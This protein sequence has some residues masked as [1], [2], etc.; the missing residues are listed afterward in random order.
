MACWSTKAAISL[1][2]VKI[3]IFRAPICRAHRAAIFAIAQL[4]C[5]GL[6]RSALRSMSVKRAAP[7]GVNG[8]TSVPINRPLPSPEIVPTH[9]DDEDEC[10]MRC[11]LQGRRDG[12]YMGIYTSPQKESVQ[13]DFLWGTVTRPSMTE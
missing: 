10:M 6:V 1:K 3:E 5:N 9:S 13:V 2:R 4:S 12:G 8:Q 7:S 11:L